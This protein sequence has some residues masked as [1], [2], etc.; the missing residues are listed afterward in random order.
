LIAKSGFLDGS[1]V[2]RG[3][4]VVLDLEMRHAADR[5][6]VGRVLIGVEKELL[7]LRCNE[8]QELGDLELDR[9]RVRP[10][11]GFLQFGSALLLRPG[12]AALAPQ[13]A[14]GEAVDVVATW[15]HRLVK[16]DWRVLTE[17]VALDAVERDRLLNQ[18]LWPIQVMEEK[19]VSPRR[20][21]W[22][23]TVS[24]E[25]PNSRAIWRAQE[26]ET[27][28]MKSGRWSCGILSQ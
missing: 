2:P 10:A 20:A 27:S 24:G 25:M 3:G 21:V 11:E 28:R 8:P 26:Q 13:F 1:R 17:L 18:A 7:R 23:R 14:V 15:F 9:F 22:R 16:V 5:P 4:P 6:D 19:R 12:H